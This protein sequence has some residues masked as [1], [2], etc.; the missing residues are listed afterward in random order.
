MQL[1]IL[2]QV[3]TFKN[4]PAA[5][6]EIFAKINQFLE[7]SGLVLSHLKVDD[8]EV[9]EDYYDYLKDRIDQVN[10]IE[11]E[12]RTMAGILQDAL[13]TAEEY[14]EQA[15]PEIETLAAEFYQGPSGASWERFQQLLD[16]VDWL[17]Q[18]VAVIDQ[19]TTKPAAWQDYLLIID[20][21]RDD[22]ENLEAALENQDYVVIGD[23]LSYE[24]I[25]C[26]Q[27]FRAII[28]KTI[29]CEGKNNELH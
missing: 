19:N 15:L 6:D 8:T 28:K 18:L 16:G 14:L 17:N 27:E 25:P 2:D 22:L 13:L 3:F 26:F 12:V 23:L 21:I 4:E 29:A 5:L 10:L 9:Y 20:R 1:K 24:L 11:V 7:E